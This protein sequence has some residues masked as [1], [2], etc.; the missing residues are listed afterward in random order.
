MKQTIVLWSATSE[1]HLDIG[2]KHIISKINDNTVMQGDILLF[3]DQ[4][5]DIAVG[6]KIIIDK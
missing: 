1:D 3:H 4:G 6:I 2:K 5:K